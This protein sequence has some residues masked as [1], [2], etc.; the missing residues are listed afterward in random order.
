VTNLQPSGERVWGRNGA[1]SIDGVSSLDFGPA[2]SGAI[3][4]AKAF[5]V[6]HGGRAFV[7][8]PPDFAS[9]NPGYREKVLTAQGTSGSRRS[10]PDEGRLRAGCRAG[11]A[12]IRTRHQI[13]A[14]FNYIDNETGGALNRSSFTYSRLETALSIPCFSFNRELMFKPLKTNIEFG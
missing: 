6:L 13:T 7:Q 2:S 12:C 4:C 5:S 1:H 11:S 3:F 14:D 8:R 9:L 10:C